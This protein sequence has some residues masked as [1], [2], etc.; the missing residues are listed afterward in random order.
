MSKLDQSL[1][2]SDWL[3]STEGKLSVDVVESRDEIIVRSAISGVR[4]SDL[5][6]S[7][8]DDTLTIRGTRSHECEESRH[9]QVHVQECH[10]GTFSRTVILPSVI[11]PDTVDATLRRGILTVRMKKVEMDKRIRVLELDDL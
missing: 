6:M 7:L 5:D 10:W 3:S 4:A 9:D 2:V 1:N 8:S 11:D